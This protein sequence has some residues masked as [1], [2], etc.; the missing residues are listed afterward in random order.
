MPELNNP[1]NPNF[2]INPISKI[3]LKTKE[4]ILWIF[5]SKYG[6]WAIITDIIT[7]QTQ[8]PS[9]LINDI[10]SSRDEYKSLN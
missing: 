9:S 3:K 1:Q 10:Q 4:D 7:R 8:N 5:Y 6:F 2:D